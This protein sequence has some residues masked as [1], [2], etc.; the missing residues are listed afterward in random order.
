MLPVPH[1]ATLGVILAGGRATRMGSIDKPFL[2]LAGRTLLAHITERLSPQCDGLVISANG[3]TDRFRE[4]GLPVVR[5]DVP[6]YPGPLAGL[7][8]TLD[9]TATHHPSIDW[10]V[11]VTGD[12]PF[13][14]E[15]LVSRLHQAREAARAPLACAASDERLHHAIGLW[16]VHLRQ[17]LRLALTAKDL[18]SVRD[19]AGLHG[20]ASA[21]W[22]TVPFDPFFNINTPADL[23]AAKAL[24]EQYPDRF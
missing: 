21:A 4:T 6:D 14:P 3:D 22:A 10:V 16:P 17:D 15:D 2:T 9:W 18:R 24:V 11:S 1:P 20:A 19:W 13:I 5:D 7:L 23:V 8:A 12:T